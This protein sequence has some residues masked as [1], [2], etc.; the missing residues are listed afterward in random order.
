MESEEETFRRDVA[1]LLISI[2]VRLRTVI[3]H[4]RVAVFT[5]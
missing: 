5:L 4:D 3:H 1:W 2:L